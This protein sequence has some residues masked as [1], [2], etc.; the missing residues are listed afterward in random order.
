MSGMVLPMPERGAEVKQW[1]EETLTSRYRF[2]RIQYAQ[3][4]SAGRDYFLPLVEFDDPSDA[5]RFK[6]RWV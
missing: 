5:V 1:C 4:R 3:G 6:L 2:Q